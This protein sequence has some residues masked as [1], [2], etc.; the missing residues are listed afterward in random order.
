MYL[1]LWQIIS[2][3]ELFSTFGGNNSKMK[4][5]LLS[6]S[7]IL[8][9]I[10]VKAQRVDRVKIEES[11][12][13]MQRFSNQMKVGLGFQLTGLTVGLIY[14]ASADK[15]PDPKETKTVSIVTSTLVVTGLII[16]ISSLNHAYIAGTKLE[17]ADSG[18]GVKLRF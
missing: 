10:S 14:T 2:S 7:I 4:T 3:T 11:G 13:S 6:I 9:S 18:I 8:L 16:Q 5:L 15:Y 17:V 1:E 12:Y